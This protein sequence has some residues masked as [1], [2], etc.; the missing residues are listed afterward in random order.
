MGFV[1]TDGRDEPV[2]G[3]PGSERL[4]MFMCTDLE[5]GESLDGLCLPK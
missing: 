5:E 4:Y 2:V 3:A 1:R